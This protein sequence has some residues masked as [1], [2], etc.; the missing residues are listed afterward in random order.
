MFKRVFGE[1]H[2]GTL[3]SMANLA[4]TYS[5]QGR[6]KEAEELEVQMMETRKRVLGE[7]KSNHESSCFMWAEGGAVM[8]CFVIV[9]EY[10]V[11]AFQAFLLSKQVGDTALVEHAAFP[12]S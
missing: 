2:P 7:D 11:A 8:C 10:L 9:V 1:K 5:N 6:R 3:I 4:L 12:A